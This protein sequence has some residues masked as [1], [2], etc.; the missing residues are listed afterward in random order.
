M[1]I[2]TADAENPEELPLDELPAGWVALVDELA[3]E[4]EEADQ[5]TPLG[6]P[7]VP[8]SS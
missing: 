8:C 1:Y 3:K 5:A 4:V 2:R 6:M 7:S